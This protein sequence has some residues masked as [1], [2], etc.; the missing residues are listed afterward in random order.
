MLEY[1]FSWGG[2]VISL[3]GKLDRTQWLLLFAGCFILG[4]L[5]M[6]SGSKYT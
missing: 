4:I 6:K 3:T 5:L 2:E 1:I